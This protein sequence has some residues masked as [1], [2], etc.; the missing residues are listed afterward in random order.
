[1]GHYTVYLPA[2]D[3]KRIMKV[4]RECPGTKWEVFSK[5]NKKIIEEKNIT[6]R[7]VSNDAFI[8]SMVSAEGVL[9]GA[10]FETPAEAL[11]MKKK[12]MVIPMKGQFEQQC[13]AAAL[14][15]MGVP[16]IKSLKKK[17]VSQI[18]EWISTKKV[19]VVDYPDSTEAIVNNLLAEHARLNINAIQ[20]GK[21]VYSLKKFRQ[22]TLRKIAAQIL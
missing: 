7:P 22:V 13:N 14:K 12:L 17:H 11:F 3:D 4:L 9:C 18:K 10:G 6:I 16:V 19:V 8:N 2:Y 5:H 1:M 20:P 21:K 15:K